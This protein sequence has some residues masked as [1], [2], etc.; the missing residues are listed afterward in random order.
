[1][2]DQEPIE[3]FLRVEP[4]DDE[5]IVVVRG[6]P[7]TP[8]KFLEHAHRQAR[9]FT[10]RGAPMY[11]VSV[12]LTVAG[13]DLDALLAGPLAS[14]STYATA[15]VGIV[16]AAGFE[17]LPTFATPHYDLLLPG[18]QYPD[19]DRARAVFSDPEPNPFKRRGRSR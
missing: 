13:W 18:G 12:N 16:R 10:F 7:I 11:S 8:E 4:I 1:M 6:G 9:E 19:A 17:L 5:T 2:P 15:T 3:T 14:R